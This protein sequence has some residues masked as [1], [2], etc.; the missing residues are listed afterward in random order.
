MTICR[1]VVIGAGVAGLACALACARAG[2][3]VQLLEARTVVAHVPA[4]VDVVPNMLRDFAKL[5]VAEACVRRGFAYS[6]LAVVDEHG[7]EA[8][9]LLTKRL[10]GPQLPPAVGIALDDLLD[11]LASAALQAGV[12][13]HRGCAVQVVETSTGR[14]VAEDGQVFDADLVVLATGSESAL[15]QRLFGAMRLPAVHHAWWH[16]LLLRPQGLERT[17]WM[18]GSADR[19]LLLV[20][21]GMSRAGVAVV[22]R[23]PSGE[24]AN[25]GALTRMLAAWGALPR[26]IAAAIDPSQP[27]ALRLAS[28]ALRSTPWHRDTV[29]CVGAAAHSIAPAFGHASAQAVDD[30]VVLGELLCAGIESSLLPEH[31][32]ERRVPR[33][34]RLHAL[35][36]RATQWMVRP[37]PAMNL[38][39][40]ADDFATLVAEPA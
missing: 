5:G 30:A 8:F 2:A 39:R 12:A 6:D 26:R 34:R 35:I 32:T 16:T 33:A 38:M 28:G 36:E 22:G 20:P 7:D 21:L 37:E 27:V 40:L 24:E 15:A 13:L 18:A 11:L 17:T 3:Q 31:F 29:V 14:V 19:R 25:G 4:H 9:R 23:I 1:V 10:V